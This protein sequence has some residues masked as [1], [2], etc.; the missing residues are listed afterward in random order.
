MAALLI[1]AACI[2]PPMSDASLLRAQQYY[3]HLRRSAYEFVREDVIA[4]GDVQVPLRLSNCDSDAV[5]AWRE[6]WKGS[7]PSG[8]GNWDC[9]STDIIV[10]EMFTGIVRPNGVVTGTVQGT[11]GL[12]DVRFV[13]GTFTLTPLRGRPVD[14]ESVTYALVPERQ[15]FVAGS[16]Y[17][18]AM[19]VIARGTDGTT[20]WTD[21]SYLGFE[22][23]EGCVRVGARIEC[24][25]S[26]TFPL[27]IT[28]TILPGAEWHIAG[29]SVPVAADFTG[30][31]VI[32]TFVD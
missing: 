9:E 24:T 23:P 30:Q 26:A 14:L 13:N 18:V 17:N 12:N 31:Q 25:E 27:V 2:G 3:A 32:V 7:H 22:A 28:V 6:T 19:L 8:W 16:T 1:P 11:F 15:E 5:A 21:A 29:T 10:R 4:S 20:A